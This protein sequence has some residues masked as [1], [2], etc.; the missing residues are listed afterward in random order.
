M[1]N[2][3]KKL[4]ILLLILILTVIIYFSIKNIRQSN[5]VVAKSNESDDKILTFILSLDDVLL[6][7]YDTTSS[8]SLTSEDKIKI[9]MR[10]IAQNSQKYKEKFIDL[11]QN[12]VIIQDK[13]EYYQISYMDKNDFLEIMDEIFD[14]KDI[15]ILDSVFY[16][17]KTGLIAIVPIYGECIVYDEKE[18]INVDKQSDMEY[19]VDIQYKRKLM[20][21]ENV[22]HIKYMISKKNEKCSVMGFAVIDSVI[23][24]Q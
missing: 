5:Q 10:Y 15:N 3:L 6:N 4:L 16:D 12:F 7:S 22:I 18:I 20:Q 24:E 14:I 19:T 1:K 23:T 17:S 13:T 21:F 9:T 2:M 8:K 11:E